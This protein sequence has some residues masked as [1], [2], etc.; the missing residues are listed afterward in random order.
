[1]MKA[2]DLRNK[3]HVAI[4]L[5]IIIPVGIRFS[6]NV[7]ELIS[8]TICIYRNKHNTVRSRGYFIAKTWERGNASQQ[9][10]R[11]CKH[12]WRQI[13]LANQNAQWQMV[14]QLKYFGRRQLAWTQWTV[15][16][17]LDKQTNWCTR[18]LLLWSYYKNT[19]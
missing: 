9:N 18:I 4:K 5:N 15:H 19:P 13:T 1:M 12:R 11:F 17:F 14:H 16:N 6:T 8:F 3:E 10:R 2:C 7:L